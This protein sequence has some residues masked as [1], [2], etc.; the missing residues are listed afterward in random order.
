MSDYFKEFMVVKDKTTHIAIDYC[1]SDRFQF[2]KFI[3]GVRITERDVFGTPEL[4]PILDTLFNTRDY[5]ITV[6]GL[7]TINR[8]LEFLCTHNSNQ[9]DMIIK[10]LT[11][12]S[13]ENHVDYAYKCLSEIDGSSRAETIINYVKCLQ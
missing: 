6:G 5:I 11:Y 12:L 3:P 7:H 1:S 10:F 13:K 9:D 8:I 2:F 4:L